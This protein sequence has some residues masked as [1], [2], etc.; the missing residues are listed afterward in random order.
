MKII[1]FLEVS[2]SNVKNCVS[3]DVMRPAMTGVYFDLVN[4]CMVCTDSHILMMFPIHIEWSQEELLLSTLEREEILK[5][6]SKI[7][8][9]ELFDKK[10]YMG[11]FKNYFG[12]VS[13]DF[14]DPLYAEVLHGEERVFRCKY[15]DE[16]FPNYQAVLPKDESCEINKIGMHFKIL[17]R[18]AKSLPIKSDEKSF[19]FTFY[20]KNKPIVFENKNYEIK[21]LLMP[22]IGE[23]L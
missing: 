4:K 21:G 17:D 7:L 12:V 8:P 23:S 20:G 9:V 5:K 3:D 1:N 16:V 2:A 14:S 22:V 10:K 18:I 19:F 6:H 15:I 11:D 13:Y